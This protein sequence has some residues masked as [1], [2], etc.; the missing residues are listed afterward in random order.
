VECTPVGKTYG[1]DFNE[2]NYDLPVAK[3]EKEPKRSEQINPIWIKRGDVLK[4]N[5]KFLKDV[6]HLSVDKYLAI[7]STVG[8]SKSFLKKYRKELNDGSILPW[9]STNSTRGWCA[10]MT[11]FLKTYDLIPKGYLPYRDSCKNHYYLINGATGPVI[12]LTIYQGGSSDENSMERYEFFKTR[13]WKKPST[14]GKRLNKAFEKHI[15]KG[16]LQKK[17]V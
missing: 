11:R 9:S 15:N 17:S 4:N 2:K 10:Q 16:N 12:D 13:D 3:Q 6:F 7:M 14:D 5:E 1:K 8:P